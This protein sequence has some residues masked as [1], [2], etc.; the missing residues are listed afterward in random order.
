M[1]QNDENPIRVMR[2]IAR[3]NVGGP[4]VQVSGLMRGF[5]SCEFDHRLYTGF[6]SAD[7]A[8]YLYSNATDVKAMRIEGLGRHISLGGDIKAFF[9]LVKVIRDFKP[10]VIHTHTAKAGFL[11]RIASIISSQ[12][13]IR[14]HTFH[15]HLLNGY[16]G[17]F[18]L[19][20]VIAAERTLGFFT[21]QLLAVGNK[22]RQDLLQARIGSVG[23]FDVMPPG[24]S[25]NQLP[26]KKLSKEFYGLSTDVLQCAF[27]GRIT[28]IK[29]PDRFLDV[30]AEIKKRGVA[31]NFFI[32]GDGELLNLC[33]ERITNED[34][35]V[36]VLSWQSNI[37]KV[38]AA[39]DMVV[40]T[41]DNEGTPLSLIQAGM[42]G[43]PVV[44][45]GVGSVPE[46]VLDGITGIITNSDVTEISDALEK[47][48]TSPE[49]RATMG[50]NAQE[51]TLTNF[52]TE[53]LVND[54]EKLY[55]RLIANQA[56]S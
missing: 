22:V 36:K 49:L 32:A 34:L 28:Q 14:V 21:D 51:F 41:S 25:I 6:C 18:K 29:R 2:I 17:S 33:K 52:G 9:S 30:A 48:A 20:L 4:A 35:K 43:M 3:M 16:F 38:L 5:N 23:K 54:H 8:D 53:R 26:S 24:L 12:P 45:T 37:E 40:L 31:I 56:K 11:G 47:L 27:I 1:N 7:E 50:R 44:T 42:A 10:H 39:A 15:G 13:S 19:T 46:V 55:K